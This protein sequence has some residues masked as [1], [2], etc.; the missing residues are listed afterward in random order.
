MVGYACI[1]IWVCED[2]IGLGAFEQRRSR[3]GMGMDHLGAS[4]TGMGQKQKA[5]DRL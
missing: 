3:R 2:G 5:T 1:R 4:S